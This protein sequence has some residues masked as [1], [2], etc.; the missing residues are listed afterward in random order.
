MPGIEVTNMIFAS[1]QLVWISWR[2]ADNEHVLSL[3]HNNDV[4]FSFVT[5]GARIH[6]YS[7]LDRLQDKAL[8]CDAD[9]VIYIQPRDEPALVETGDNLGDMTSELKPGESTSEFVAAGPKNY[10]YK[11]GPGKGKT[12]CKVRR[13]TLNYNALQLVNIDRIRDMILKRD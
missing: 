3:R 5:A 8:Y 2:F 4:V 12:V 11:T 9:S 1:D 7:Y 13:I 10:A 6:L